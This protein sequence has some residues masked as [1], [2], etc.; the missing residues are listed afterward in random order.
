MYQLFY[1]KQT[2][3]LEVYFINAINVTDIFLRSVVYISGC[4]SLIEYSKLV[5]FFQ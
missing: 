3:S 5:S 1:M 2:Q 4:L